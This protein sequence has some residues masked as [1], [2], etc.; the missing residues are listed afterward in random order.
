VITAGGGN[1]MWGQK[2]TRT[3]GCF[4]LCPVPVQV[5][6]NSVTGYKTVH[7]ELTMEFL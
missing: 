2:S 5:P 6:C 4:H 3:L 1:I 7:K